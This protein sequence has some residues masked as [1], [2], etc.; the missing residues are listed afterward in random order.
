ML[1]GIVLS[2]LKFGLQDDKMGVK[3]GARYHTSRAITSVLGLFCVVI[4]VYV[5]FK[6]R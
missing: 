6:T 3:Y 4:V 5:K 1:A 2:W